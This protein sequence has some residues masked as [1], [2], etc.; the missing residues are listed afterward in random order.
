MYQRMIPASSLSPGWSCAFCK[1]LDD[2]RIARHGSVVLGGRT[3]PLERTTPW[4]VPALNGAGNPTIML[5]SPSMGISTMMAWWLGCVQKC[6][7]SKLLP[8]SWGKCFFIKGF[9]GI[10]PENSQTK[11]RD[12]TWDAHLSNIDGDMVEII[13]V[14]K[15]HKGWCFCSFKIFNWVYGGFLKWRYPKSS[16]SLDRFSNESRG[17]GIPH[18]KK[19]PYLKIGVQRNH[20]WSTSYDE[21]FDAGFPTFLGQADRTIGIPRCDSVLQQFNWTQTM[22]FFYKIT[23]NLDTLG[24][25]NLGLVG[26]RVPDGTGVLRIPMDLSSSVLLKRPERGGKHPISRQSQISSSSW[27][28]GHVVLLFPHFNISIE[29]W[30]VEVPQSTGPPWTIAGNRASGSCSWRVNGERPVE[31]GGEKVWVYGAWAQQWQ[32]RVHQTKWWFALAKWWDNQV[33]QVII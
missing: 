32:G 17:F 3:C 33:I 13:W 14:E 12:M 4:K 19:P 7:G 23:D 5:V 16:K 30:Y 27:V 18:F 22:C 6:G 9:S 11:P 15:N 26:N 28:V 10:H 2:L 29:Y 1:A 20:C 24:P 21:N 8:C 31:V 25:Q